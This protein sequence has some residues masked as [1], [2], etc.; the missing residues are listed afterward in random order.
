MIARWPTAARGL[1]IAYGA[2]TITCI[3]YFVYWMFYCYAPDTYLFVLRHL[4]PAVWSYP[5]ID[6]EAVLKA[7][8][9]ARQGV[10]VL[11]PNACMDGGL[12]QYSPLLLKAMVLPL[13]V[14]QRVPLALCLDGLFLLSLFVLP[15]PQRWS[16]FWAFLLAGLSTSVLFALERANIDVALYL[17]SFG[18]VLL[19]LRDG[20]VRI[21]CYAIIIAA[22]AIK[23]Y[24]ASL[25]ALAVREPLRRFTALASVA[26]L[27]ALIFVFSYGDEV[28]E[29]VNQLFRG[30][31][32]SNTFAASRLPEGIAWIVGRGKPEDGGGPAFSV[33]VQ[34]LLIVYVA[35][36]TWNSVPLFLS[37]IREL[38]EKER[39]LFVAAS[40]ITI[41]CFFTATNIYYREIFLVPTIPGFFAL[42]RGATSQALR[43]QARSACWTGVIILWSG[44]IRYGSGDLLRD[45]LGHDAV[46]FYFAAWLLCEVLWWWLVGALLAVVTCY[47]WDS[48]TIVDL[49]LRV[50]S[51]FISAA[52][53]SNPSTTP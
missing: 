12:F 19:L 25:M 17:L 3:V 35:F 31:P 36:R 20:L 23:F 28:R 47:M 8:D 42:N 6:L 26:F 37:G 30:T 34:F 24:P 32:F 22:A 53:G 5:F 38:S 14:N 27:A 45:T 40:L 39:I 48:R 44:F 50:S 15:R 9:C 13:G 43:S 18:A 52:N 41:S 33:M 16:E 10:S 4:E 1:V 2:P 11:V 46:S 7:I 51:C 21:A 29:I 49:R